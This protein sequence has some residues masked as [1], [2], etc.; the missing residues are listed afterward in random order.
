MKEIREYDLMEK[1]FDTLVSIPIYSRLGG[2]VYDADAGLACL[3]FV[4]DPDKATES[5]VFR[6]YSAGEELEEP[7]S[8]VGSYVENEQVYHVVEL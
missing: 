8:Y 3:V 6:V 7:C 4:V 2:V 5:R 1:G